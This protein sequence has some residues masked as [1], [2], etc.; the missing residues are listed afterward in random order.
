VRGCEPDSDGGAGIR[1][2]GHETSPLDGLRE[3]ALLGRRGA[4]ALTAQD[5]AVGAHQAAEVFD[6]L[7]IH[8]VL[9]LAALVDDLGLLDGTGETLKLAHGNSVLGWARRCLPDWGKVRATVKG[10]ERMVGG[11]GR[12][13]QLLG[14]SDWF[15]GRNAV[16]SIQ[17]PLPG[18]EHYQNDKASQEDGVLTNFAPT[19]WARADELELA[20]AAAGDVDA[21]EDD[22]DDTQGEGDNREGQGH[23]CGPGPQSGENKEG[24]DGLD[25]GDGER[26]GR[27]QGLGQNLVTLD[28]EAESLGT[29]DGRNA[30]LK[31]LPGAET[32]CCGSRE[33][34]Q[35]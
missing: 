35:E 11:R 34:D 12:R 24:T 2:Q 5:L 23:R 27:D 33:A 8:K 29:S 31:F 14:R 22:G 9:A 30:G 17:S 32:E 20:K 16:F 4:D 21:A 7:V 26:G 18:T 3:H 19:D 15:G 28:T 25:P 10:Q 6:V 13:D 1:Q